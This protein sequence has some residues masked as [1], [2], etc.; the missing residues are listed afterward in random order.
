MISDS[1]IKRFAEA[2]AK[3]EGFYVEGSV[4]Q[5]ANNP[6]DLTD[7]GDVGYGTI[8]TS[9]PDGSKITIYPNVNDGWA[10]A[11]RKFRRMLSGASEVYTL[12]L[13]MEEVGLK[14]SGDPNW[15]TNV[16]EL[17][18]PVGALTVTGQ[19]TLAEI[20]NADLQAQGT[21]SAT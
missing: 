6:T 10:A 18:S 20:A 21:E 2:I 19:T 4:P 14:Y 8:Q 11:Y 1:L 15:G 13:S 16:A 3:Q 7:D 5:R 17:L 9:G 12:A